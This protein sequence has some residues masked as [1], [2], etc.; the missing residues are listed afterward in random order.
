LFKSLS[1]KSEVLSNLQEVVFYSQKYDRDTVFLKY[2][3]AS[4]EGFETAQ[5]NLAYLLNEGKVDEC[6][7]TFSLNRYIFIRLL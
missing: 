2:A 5:Y 3:M 1:E 6:S 4:E 7:F